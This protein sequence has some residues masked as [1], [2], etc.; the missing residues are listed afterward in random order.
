MKKSGWEN[1]Y[2]Y[3]KERDESE[4]RF[5]KIKITHVWTQNKDETIQIAKAVKI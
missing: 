1:I 2:D 4:F 5:D 3:L